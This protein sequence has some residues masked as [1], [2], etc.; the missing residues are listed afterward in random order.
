[1]FKD[2]ASIKVKAGK[3]GNG[4]VAFRREKYVPLGGPAG[5]DGGKGGSVIFIADNQINTL[6]DFSYQRHLNAKDGENGQSKNKHGKNGEDL[7]VKV[8]VGTQIFYKETGELLYDFTTHGQEE[9]IAIGGKGGRGNTSFK[10]HKNP[11]PKFAENG[12][13]GETFDLDLELKVLADVGLIGLPNA[14]K[15]TLISVL[16]NANPY[17]AD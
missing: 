9:V 5:G 11:A 12:D 4:I 6:L 10:T 7:K 1:M 2:K 14:G 16:S 8:P 13:L 15:S 17:I 3:G